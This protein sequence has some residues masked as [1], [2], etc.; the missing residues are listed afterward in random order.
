M[1]F[2][3]PEDWVLQLEGV[4]LPPTDFKHMGRNNSQICDTFPSLLKQSTAPWSGCV[5]VTIVHKTDSS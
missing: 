1:N 5:G 4:K 3:F 2:F